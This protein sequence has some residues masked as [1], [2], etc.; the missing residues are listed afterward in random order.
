M[1]FIAGD[2]SIPA[3][4]LPRK[5]PTMIPTTITRLAVA[6]LVIGA[7]VAPTPAPAAEKDPVVA[8][9]N[10][11]EIHL[12]DVKEARGR[13]PE[14]FRRGPM[15]GVFGILVNTLIDSKIMAAEA[16][17]QGIADD[18]AFKRRM[19]IIT[20]QVLERA[21][22]TRHLERTLTDDML[23]KSYDDMVKNMGDKKEIRARHILLKTKKEALA[24]I[25]ELNKGAD[26]A[27]LA[28]KKSIGP[29]K[30]SGGDL[31]YFGEGQ[32]VPA[33]FKAAFALD[34]GAVTKAPVKTRFGW[35]VIKLEDKR[36]VK[37]P[38]FEEVRDRLGAEISR[39][40]GGEYIESLRKKA[41]VERFN[42]D[43]TPIKEKAEED[44]K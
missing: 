1:C 36:D 30:K 37:P 20:E 21:L 16:R 33:F 22:L 43:G 25:A 3:T 31:G 7:A 2:V 41:K 34:V 32:M 18:P 14:R 40:I 11:V 23:K 12:A 35:H 19:A 29:S 39:K 5:A 28:K 13:L 27:E 44:K 26:F 42:P 10:G 15:E 9:V 24:V 4:H 38:T 6:V 8:R 17:K